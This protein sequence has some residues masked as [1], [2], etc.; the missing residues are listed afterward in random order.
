[1]TKGAT[2]ALSALRTVQ[3]FNAEDQERE[4]FHG[5]IT[6]I[7]ELARKEAVATG[8]FWGSSGWSGNLTLLGLLA[9]GMTNV[10]A[11]IIIPNH[12]FIFRWISS[13]CRRTD[14]RFTE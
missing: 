9:Y 14:N 2:E 7:L 4:K 3:A 1:M 12:S 13:C 6:G 8:I 5:R 10:H 11:L